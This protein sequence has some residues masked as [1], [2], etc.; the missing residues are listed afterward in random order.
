MFHLPKMSQW[1]Q[2]TKQKLYEEALTVSFNWEK[3]PFSKMFQ[4]P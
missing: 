3:Y 1:E 2:Y 4:I